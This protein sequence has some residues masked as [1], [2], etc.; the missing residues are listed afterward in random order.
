MLKFLYV[1]QPKT[2]TAEATGAVK[3]SDVSVVYGYDGS[4]HRVYLASLVLA[5]NGY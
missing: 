5:V 3:P 4:R 2:H 1:L